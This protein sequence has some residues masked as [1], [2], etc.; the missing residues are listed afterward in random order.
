[1]VAVQAP[2]RQLV[3]VASVQPDQVHV[4][5]CHWLDLTVQEVARNVHGPHLTLA[6][7]VKPIHGLAGHMVNR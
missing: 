7:A 3:H 5:P 1:L 6:E 4:R 2:E